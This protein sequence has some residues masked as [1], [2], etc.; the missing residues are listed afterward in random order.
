M[1]GKM[2]AARLRVTRLSFGAGTW[3]ATSMNSRV[4]S[5]SWRAFLYPRA[6][7]HLPALCAEAESSSIQA[8]RR[9]AHRLPTYVPAGRSA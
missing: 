2:K 7:E 4:K 9:F 5:A 1:S 8:L 6:L 3:N